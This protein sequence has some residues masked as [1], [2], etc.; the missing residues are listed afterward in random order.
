[1]VVALVALGVAGFGSASASAGVSASASASAVGPLVYHATANGASQRRFT[2]RRAGDDVEVLDDAAGV[3][4][5]EAALARISAVEISGV[6]GPVDNTLTVDLGGGPIDVRGGVDWDG[7]VGG[8]NTLDLV[9]GGGPEVSDPSGPHSGTITVGPTTVRYRD[10]APINDT[11]PSVSFIFNE[12]GAGPITLSD[13]GLVGTFETLEISGGGDFESISVANKTVITIHAAA[14]GDAILLDDALTPA[15]LTSLI[16]DGAD[17]GVGT[18]TFTVDTTPGVPTTINRATSGSEDVDIRGTAAGGPLT[19]TSSGATGATGDDVTI[20]SLAPATTGGTVAGL[21]ASVT[22]GSSDAAPD[23][24]VVDDSGDTTGQSATIGDSQLAGLAPSVIDYTGSQLSGL[25]VNFGSGSDTADVTPSANF[26]MA[27]DGGPP[28][29]PATPGDSLDVDLSG[30]TSPVLTS[31]VG[32]TGDS[33]SWTFGNRQ[34]VTFSRWETLVPSLAEASD[35]SVTGVEG[36]STGSVEIGSFTDSDPTAP[37]SDFTATVNWGDGSSTSVGTITQPGGVGT[38]FEVTGAHTYAEEG[39]Y[40]V[41]VTVSGEGS[42][43]VLSGMAAVSDAPLDAGTPLTLA[44]GPGVLTSF[45][46]VATFT[47]TNPVA[48]VSDFTAAIS[49]GDGSST[50]VGTITQPDG[51]GTPFVVA[52]SHTYAAPGTFSL[53]VAVT[54][55]GGSTVTLTGTVD[56]APPGVPP[57]FGGGG[58]G[59]SAPPAAPTVS[60]VAGPDRIATSIAASQDRFPAAGSA[61]AVVL[62]GDRTF[63]DALAGTPLAAAKGG[64]L[65]LTSG[66][67]LEP[68]VQA[69]IQRVLPAGGTVYVL[70]GASAISPA[71][72]STLGGLGYTVVRYGGA[73]RFATARIVATE[74]L[75]DPSTI[76]LVAGL[77]FA[78]GLAAG[79]AAAAA[80]GAVLLSDGSSLDPGTAAYLAAHPGDTVYAVGGPAAVA[81]PAATAIAGADRYATAVDLA[82]RFFSKPTVVGVATGT[83]FPD[84]LSGGA[85]MAGLGGPMLL[86]AAAPPPELLAY[87]AG[88]TTVTTVKVFGGSAVV[89]DDDLAQ[90]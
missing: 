31:T 86:T 24:L 82:T 75:G 23:T 60:R 61:G 11:I 26:P 10:I 83:D 15:G 56:V 74:G 87:L 35:P 52:G 48:P 19:L 47:D 12:P 7:G 9:G 5:A 37:V 27:L 85:E 63:A 41:T 58:G 79:P 66:V 38:P 53:S 67:T 80:D 89:P 13:G 72:T 88:A 73:D 77:D 46:T 69:E 54:D 51:V 16:I 18:N 78:D 34:T 50:S 43:L 70:G 57:V 44:A 76:F 45:P 32:P 55:I 22:V 42:T 59:G 81:D 62:A 68:S 40:I 14:G 39:D 17:H 28:D 29:P 36:S 3:V 21:A 4:V 30:T 20:G 64:P 71:V 90:F 65:L 25:T 33:G 49:W 6:D 1:M 8:Y 84:A 2:V